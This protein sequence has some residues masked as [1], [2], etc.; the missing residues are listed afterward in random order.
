MASTAS[1]GQGRRQEGADKPSCGIGRPITGQ[2]KPASQASLFIKC[3]RGRDRISGREPEQT[4]LP[5]AELPQNDPQRARRKP[6][7]DDARGLHESSKTRD[8][9]EITET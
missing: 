7:Q 8:E 3:V 1:A 6:D 2:I 4:A 5:P 9:Y